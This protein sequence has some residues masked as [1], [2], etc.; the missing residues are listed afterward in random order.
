MNQVIGSSLFKPGVHTCVYPVYACVH[1]AHNNARPITPHPG[2]LIYP[3][4]SLQHSPWLR[5]RCDD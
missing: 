1:T 2:G 5:C 4:A 3:S